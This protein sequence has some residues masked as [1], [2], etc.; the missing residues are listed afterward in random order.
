MANSFLQEYVFSLIPKVDSS[1]LKGASK[2][3]ATKISESMQSSA[4][5]FYN[6]LNK[7]ENVKGLKSQIELIERYKEQG[8]QLTLEEYKK[9]E[10]L[11]K[12]V[13][14]MDLTPGT[15]TKTGKFAVIGVKLIEKISGAI[16]AIQGSIEV[17]QAVEKKADEI[18]KQATK[19]SNQFVS[20]QSM[21]VDKDTR[22]IMATFGV[23]A[24]GAQGIQAALSGSGMDI[25]DL[26]IATAGQRKLFSRLYGAYIEGINKIDP[27]KLEAF[28]ENVQE[29]QALRAEFDIKIQTAIMKVLAE[30]DAL[31]R[32]LDTLS[33]G[34]ELVVDIMSS[35]G[36]AFAFDTVIN[37]LNAI[38]EISNAFKSAGAWL[39]GVKGTNIANTWN[40][41][42]TTN[43]N[44]GNTYSGGFSTALNLQSSQINLL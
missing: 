7:E 41:S 11:K 13:G 42:S 31:P 32:L 10:S 27:E 43:Y 18:V 3:I 1:A 38:L 12:Q 6:E 14:T 15:P 17:T 35:P 34:L 37:F 4:Q 24:T 33:K 22:N 21:F 2:Q 20:S 16:T 44:Y 25:S 39:L 30:S 26:G 28:N 23:N 29:Y 36:V 19:I 8:G 40:N 5:S 9:Y